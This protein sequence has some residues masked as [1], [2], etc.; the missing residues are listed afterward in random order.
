MSK[1]TIGTD[2]E[3]F[4]KE[5]GTGKHRSMIEH[6]KGT[7]KKPE[8]LK[9]GA[10]LQRD[11]VA[12]EF[13]SPP[14]SS[15]MEFVKSLRA[16]FVE[17]MGKVPEDIEIV[18]EPSA[19][20]DED[21]LDH[22]EALEF[23]CDPDYDAWIPAMNPAA[24][25][26]DPTF[27]SCGGHIHLGFVEESGNDF[28]LDPWGKVHTIR[29]MDAIHGIISVILDNS[30]QAI[31]RRQLYGKAGCHRPTEYGVEYRA[32]SNFWLKSPE[33]VMLMY[34]L[35]GDVLRLMREDR[36]EKLYT[37]IGSERIQDVI[38]NGKVKEARKILDSEIRPVLSAESLEMLDIC[39]EK[40]EKYNFNEEWQ[41][42]KAEVS[43]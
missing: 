18:A 24:H 3:F 5:R 12:L 27:R 28:L 26:D 9:C 38:N 37:G 7:K 23:G 25:C 6:I 17:I 32:L 29:T 11:N 35:S 33:M 10:G 15:E 13:A 19:N 21:Q 41:L 14:A 31:K 4:G 22:P 39:I 43:A 16:A 36:A 34:R 20:F 42:K 40:A 2:P 1:Y 30:P 8:I